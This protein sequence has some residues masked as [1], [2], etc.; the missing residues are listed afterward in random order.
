[1]ESPGFER[2]KSGMLVQLEHIQTG[3]IVFTHNVR[4]YS[5]DDKD[6]NQ[7][8]GHELVHTESE[9]LKNSW[10]MESLDGPEIDAI[11]SRVR[12]RNYKTGC[13]LYSREFKLPKWGFGQQEVLCSKRAREALTMFSKF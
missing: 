11:R 3:K 6:I 8:G 9:D 5:T 7:V 4:P 1:M 10:I 12:F 2:I 13:Y